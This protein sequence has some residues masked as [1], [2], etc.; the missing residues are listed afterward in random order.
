[1]AG[2]FDE[3]SDKYRMARLVSP[4][5]SA[6]LTLG[7][8]RALWVGGTGHLNVILADDSA[9]VLMSAI[10]AGTLLPVAAKRVMSTSTTATLI[11]ALY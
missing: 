7:E 10:P 1:M 5:D 11:V 8:C 2:K 3:K 4:S 6:D 9:A